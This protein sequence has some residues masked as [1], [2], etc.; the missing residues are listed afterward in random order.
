LIS[1]YTGTP[2][3]RVPLRVLPGGKPAIAGHSGLFFNLSH[4]GELAL[5]AFADCEVGVDVERVGNHREMEGVAAHFFS[6]D[7]ADAFRRLSGET[8]AR[9]FCRTWVRKEAY[10]KATG[11]G[12]AIDPARLCVD[13]RYSVHDL[14]EIDGHLAAV[15][16]ASIIGT[17]EIQYRELQTRDF[18]TT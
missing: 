11:E 10:V 7:E 4:C 3:E 6:S 5:F 8:Q 15:V 18:Q 17:G 9:F 16:V 2:P 1:E 13:D 12:F 14:P